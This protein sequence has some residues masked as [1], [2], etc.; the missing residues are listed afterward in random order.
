[1]TG[2]KHY[3]ASEALIDG[4]QPAADDLAARLQLAQVHATLALAAAVAA[5]GW[6][7]APSHS[8]REW[9]KAAAIREPREG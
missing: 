8:A 2:P 6:G 3:L 5:V 9:D 1:M 7:E 4:V